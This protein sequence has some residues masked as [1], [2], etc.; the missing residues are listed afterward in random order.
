MKYAVVIALVALGLWLWQRNKSADKRDTS[1]GAH[2]STSTAKRKTQ[3][4]NATLIVACSTCGVHL[5]KS[6]ALLGTRGVYCC[7]SHQRQA[8]D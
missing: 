7:T 4:S 5:P 2:D 1:S 8:D 6:D 3:G